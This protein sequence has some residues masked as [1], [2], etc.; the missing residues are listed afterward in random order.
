MFYLQSTLFRGK[1]TV[2]VYSI[3]I[4]EYENYLAGSHY[5]LLVVFCE[6][7]SYVQLTVIVRVM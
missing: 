3:N 1:I 6:K 2:T 5:N 7:I 4:F